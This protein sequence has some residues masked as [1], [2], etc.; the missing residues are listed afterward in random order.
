MKQLLLNFIRKKKISTMAVTD[1]KKKR[2]LTIS[3]SNE[4][5]H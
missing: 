3:R 1:F 4:I 2:F 5:F